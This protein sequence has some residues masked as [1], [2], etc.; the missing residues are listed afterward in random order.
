MKENVRIFTLIELLVVIAIIAILAGMLLPALNKARESARSSSCQSNLKQYGLA[1]GM[2]PGDNEDFV[3]P[4]SLPRHTGGFGYDEGWGFCGSNCDTLFLNPYLP[5][6][7]QSNCDS[8]R[9]AIF[10]FSGATPK[11]RTTPLTCPNLTDLTKTCFGYTCNAI[12]SYKTYGFV[13]NMSNVYKSGRIRHP[14]RLCQITE[15]ASSS[16]LFC[17]WNAAADAD[18]GTAAKIALRHNRRANIQFV[19]GH[20]ESRCYEEIPCSSASVGYSSKFWRPEGTN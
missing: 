19:D 12:F 5:R 9:G 7:R 3:L 18:N 6:P 2:Y 15:G 14:S 17:Y 8:F 4:A 16:L 13:I 10:Y 1:C 20:V 11:L